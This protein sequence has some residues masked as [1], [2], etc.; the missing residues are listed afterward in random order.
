MRAV[1]RAS[2]LRLGVSR[3]GAWDQT[4]NRDRLLA[5]DVAARFLAEVPPNGL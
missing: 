1:A 4:S 2:A 3:D 5:G